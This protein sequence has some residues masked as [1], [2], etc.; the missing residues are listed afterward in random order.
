MQL[1]SVL[2]VKPSG[3]ILQ[4]LSL[5]GLVELDSACEFKFV[6]MQPQKSLWNIL[7]E[8]HCTRVRSVELQSIYN[9]S[10]AVAIN[11]WPSTFIAQIEFAYRTR[12][13][14]ETRFISLF[15]YYASSSNSTT[16][17]ALASCSFIAQ[18]PDRPS[19]MKK[20]N[21]DSEIPQPCSYIPSWKRL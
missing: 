2:W 16:I 9:W 4:A 18:F 20:R 6:C 21:A 13:C 17:T 19:C 14:E 15:R 1:A 10:D 7:N 8:E 11:P 12:S 5:R 3:D